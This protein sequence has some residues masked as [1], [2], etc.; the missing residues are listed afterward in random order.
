MVKNIVS[1][2]LVER[3]YKS[4]LFIRG[5]KVILD[6]DLADLYGVETKVLNQAVSRN[7]EHFPEDFM[8]KLNKEEFDNLRY[9]IDTSSYRA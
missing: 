5:H 4:I 1:I 9:Q 2:V 8:F 6:R 3:I 7:K